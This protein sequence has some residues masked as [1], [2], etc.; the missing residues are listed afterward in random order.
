MDRRPFWI[1]I[2]V[3]VLVPVLAVAWWLG[4]PLFLD[5]VVD[6]EFPVV[7]GAVND[8]TMEADAMAEAAQPTAAPDEAPTVE[9]TAEAE[10]TATATEEAQPTATM[11]AEPTEMP[12]AE[13]EPTKAPTVVAPTPTE[14]PTPPP[15]TEAPVAEPV[16]LK[17]GEFRDGDSFHQGSGQV[18]IYRLED[19]S[20][21]LR[22]ENFD[23]TN[24]P[25]LR[26]YLSQHAD[27]Q[28]VEELNS[29]TYVDIGKLKGNTGNQNY[30]L[31]AD[32]D[33]DALGSI[34]IY[35]QPFHVIFSVAALQAGG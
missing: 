30:V 12:V 18:T 19:G 24:G 10:P 1:V 31:P 21:L 34:I 17:M 26:V 7:T 11:L 3:I 5:T 27:P 13:E 20:H 8:A 4:S 6:E 33:V 23:V 14:V 25:D 15:P 9:P 16:R 32:V 22:L 28:T 2:A 29:A 35:C